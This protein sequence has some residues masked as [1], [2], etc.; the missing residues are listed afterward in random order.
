M[1][2]SP[3]VGEFRDVK[4]SDY[5]VSVEFIIPAHNG[6]FWAIPVVGYL[7]R[8][9]VLVPHLVVMLLVSILVGVAMLIL[10]IPVLFTGRYPRWG[11]ALVGG[12]LRWQLRINAFFLGLTDEY[13]PFRLSN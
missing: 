4:R 9:L 3:A 11:Y 13:P 2:G 5:G 1:Y 7:T 12:W 6:R 10:W 8:L